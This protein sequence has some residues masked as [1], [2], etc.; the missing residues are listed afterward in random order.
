MVYVFINQE[1]VFAR[2]LLLQPAR[3]VK[4]K[5]KVKRWREKE[6]KVKEK[7]AITRIDWLVN[8]LVKNV[9]GRN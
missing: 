4:K 7:E 9:F 5:K 1:V 3:S 6:K 2:M 8:V